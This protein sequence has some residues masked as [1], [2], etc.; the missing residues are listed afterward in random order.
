M[1]KVTYFDL[2][3]LPEIFGDHIGDVHLQLD[4]R[5]L[6]LE[7]Q[8]TRQSEYAVAG[9]PPKS[10]RRYTAAR[11]ALTA[12]AMLQLYDQLRGIVEPLKASGKIQTAHAVTST[13]Q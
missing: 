10:P 3:E 2:P 4:A 7:V 9:L 1:T 13:K 11:L 6:R 8:V 12:E 5:L